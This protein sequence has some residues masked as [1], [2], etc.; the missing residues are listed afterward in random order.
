MVDRVARAIAAAIDSAIVDAIVDLE[1]PAGE[2]VRF[3]ADEVAA[4]T[5]LYRADDTRSSVLAVLRARLR[6][7]ILA[8][9]AD[10]TPYP[11]WHD[12][13]AAQALLSG[14]QHDDVAGGQGRP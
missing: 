8:M 1:A 7:A 6:S 9:E 10:T 4:V 14:L 12:A 3:N 5:A 13:Q 2:R 11:D